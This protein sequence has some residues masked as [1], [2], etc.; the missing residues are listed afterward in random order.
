MRILLIDDCRNFSDVDTIAR[1]YKD[2]IA[3][4]QSEKWDVLLLDHD[5]ADFEIPENEK[6]CTEDEFLKSLIRSEY[7][8]IDG[9]FSYEIKEYT[10]YDVLCWLEQHPEHL[11]KKITLVTSNPVGRMRMQSLIERLYGK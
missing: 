5:L 1:N 10:G 2:G 11:P 3:A 8:D 4:L 9:N 7:L 6:G